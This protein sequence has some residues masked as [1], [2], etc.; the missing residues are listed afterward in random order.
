[1]GKRVILDLRLFNVRL[2]SFG[3]HLSFT[4]KQLAIKQKGL[5]SGIRGGGL[6]EHIWSILAALCSRLLLAHSVQLS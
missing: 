3:E 2:G 1:M 6:V 5:K 4:R